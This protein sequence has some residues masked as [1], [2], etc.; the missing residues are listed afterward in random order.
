MYKL[1]KKIKGEET[2]LNY[3]FKN[4]IIYFGTTAASLFDIKTVPVG[5]I[6]PGVEVQATYVNNLIDNNFITKAG[7]QVTT[8]V[9]VIL[10]IITVLF[11][12]RIPS[13]VIASISTVAIY[14]GYVIFSYYAMKISD[15][16]LV[17][18]SIR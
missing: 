9:S 5:K 15:L 12:M 18:R 6:Y 4:K 17:C 11:V 14:M 8:L 1:I 7:K 13:A 2:D 3:S 16:S 10:A